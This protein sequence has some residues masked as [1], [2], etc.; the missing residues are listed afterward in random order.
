MDAGTVYRLY[1]SVNNSATVTYW[2]MMITLTPDFFYTYI[3]QLFWPF[4]RVLALFSIAPFFGEK[5]IPK[6]TKISL[7]CLITILISTTISIPKIPLFSAAGC[8]LL[9]QQIL[10]GLL[11]AITMQIAFAIVRYAGEICKLDSFSRY[12]LIRLRV[13]ICQ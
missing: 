9:I 4:V 7:A 8:W 1:P 2:L 13:P 10:I 6:R 5:Q 3:N 12:L 11:M